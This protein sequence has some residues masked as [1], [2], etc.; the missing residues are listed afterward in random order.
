MTSRVYEA[1]RPGDP[2]E[3]V[4]ACLVDTRLAR[5]LRTR[6]RMCVTARTYEKIFRELTPFCHL[7]I[8]THWQLLADACRALEIGASEFKI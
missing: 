7:V 6:T 5:R 4:A 2:D 8:A 3:A 1:T